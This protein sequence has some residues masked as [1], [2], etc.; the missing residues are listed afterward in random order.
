[1]YVLDLFKCELLSGSLCQS[2]IVIVR[3]TGGLLAYANQSPKTLDTIT[4]GVLCVQVIYCLAQAFFLIGI[5][6][7]AFATLIISS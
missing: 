1:M 6:N 5:L 3:V 4:P 2:G 7:F